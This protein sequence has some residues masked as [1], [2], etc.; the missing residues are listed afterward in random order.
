MA[1][2][3]IDG[4]SLKEAK[5]QLSSP[6]AHYTAVTDAEGA[7]LIPNVAVGR[8]SFAVKGWGEAHL[9]V[10]GWHRG[11][12]NAPGASIQLDKKMS[13]ADAGQQLMFGENPDHPVRMAKSGVITH[14][15]ISLLLASFRGKFFGD[16]SNPYHYD[17]DPDCDHGH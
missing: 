1:S 4:R 6:V 13:S 3:S 7:F 9:Q 11:G 8:Y 5:I 16:P 12:M 17:S 14:D 10:E 2:F 15:R